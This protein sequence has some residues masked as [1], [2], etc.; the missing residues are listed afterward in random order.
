VEKVKETANNAA[1]A[2]KGAF[3]AE[4]EKTVLV[5]GE[6]IPEVRTHSAAETVMQMPSAGQDA[7]VSRTVKTEYDTAHTWEQQ[8]EGGL[9]HR[10]KETVLGAAEVV[11]EKAAVAAEVVKEKASEVQDSLAV[12]GHNARVK[13]D[14][15]LERNLGPTADA[16]K[17][18]GHKIKQAVLDD[19]VHDAELL[20]KHLQ[21]ANTSLK[22]QERTDLQKTQA[23][24]LAGYHTHTGGSTRVDA[25]LDKNLGTIVDEVQAETLRAKEDVLHQTIQVGEVLQSEAEKAAS[26][27]RR[28]SESEKAK[29]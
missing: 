17:A 24:K 13:I 1:E 21:G 7:E 6:V 27:L 4:K 28:Q 9:G 29:K 10:A 11:G 15:A 2:I 3:G 8:H 23:E 16:V 5:Q 20:S 26:S 19:A 18:E 14:N 22:E 25:V 12:T